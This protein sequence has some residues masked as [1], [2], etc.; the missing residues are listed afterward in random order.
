MVSTQTVSRGHG[1]V[2]LWV[3]KKSCALLFEVE[4]VGDGEP[5]DSGWE[6]VSECGRVGFFLLV[7]D[8]SEATLSVV[9]LMCEGAPSDSESDFWNRIVFLI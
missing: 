2:R 9:I 6:F 3:K 7:A 8:V 5:S 1:R 4:V